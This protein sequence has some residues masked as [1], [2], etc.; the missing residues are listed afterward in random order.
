MNLV[1]NLFNYSKQNSTFLPY[2]NFLSDVEKL[3]LTLNC[4]TP[5][6]YTVNNYTDTEVY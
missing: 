2:S 4:S 6:K 3:L 1:S 5:F